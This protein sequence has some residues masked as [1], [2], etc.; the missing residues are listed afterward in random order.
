MKKKILSY[1]LDINIPLQFLE[2]YNYVAKLKVEERPDYLYLETV[3]TNMAWEN[4][5]NLEE[6][7]FDWSLKAIL[8]RNH[9]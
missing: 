1:V 5:I 9:S 8:I 6:K 4:S 3:L 7:Y 2:F